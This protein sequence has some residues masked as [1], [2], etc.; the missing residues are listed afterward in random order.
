MKRPNGLVLRFYA[1]KVTNASGF[2]LPIYFVFL[3]DKGFDLAFLG[4][5]SATFSLS[6]VAV[7]I[8]T[9]YL[10]D[11]V[12]RRGS[13]AVGAVVR[14]AVMASFPFLPSKPAYLALFGV[15]AI[16]WAFRSGTQDAWLYE[17][18]QSTCDEDEYARVD[19][20]ANTLVLGTSAVAAVLG[21]LMYTVEPA[22][23]FLANAAL[24]LVGLPILYTFPP[25]ET[26]ADE[27]AFG[28][29]DAVVLLRAQARRPEVRWF[30]A[31]AAVFATAFAAT[32]PFEQPMLRAVGVP[33][34]GLGVLY[35]AFKLVSAG[36]ASTSG[37][38]EERLGVR[39]TFAVLPAV[40]ALAFA[41]VYVVPVAIVPVVFLN[42]AINTAVRPIRNKYLNDRLDDVGRATVLSGASMALSV[43]SGLGKIVNGRVT[44]AIGP[45]DGV[46]T[47]SVVLAGVGA[48]LWFAVDPVRSTGDESAT[49]DATA[50]D[51]VTAD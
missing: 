22:A 29:R 5:L 7:E 47:A 39:G 17:V 46:A 33:I 4:L 42:R 15:W 36:A 13:L 2:Y 40:Y 14:A 20:R 51:A 19:G 28:V 21:G 48:L 10:G 49:D 30:V 8:P 31:Y 24:A 26:D 6:L 12:G 35:A 9:G 1:F 3:Q 50:E 34:A 16:G 43:V 11:L 44:D 27:Q 45:I 38:L 32:R 18:L 37:Y 25:I 23:P 41:V